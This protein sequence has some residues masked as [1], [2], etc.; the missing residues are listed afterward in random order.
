VLPSYSHL[1]EDG[2]DRIGILRSSS[3]M[4]AFGLA[5]SSAWRTGRRPPRTRARTTRRAPRAGLHPTL[6]LR[7]RLRPLNT[8]SPDARR[9]SLYTIPNLPIAILTI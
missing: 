4:R 8:P 5:S 6:R 3:A 2:I 1:P 7:L 9:A